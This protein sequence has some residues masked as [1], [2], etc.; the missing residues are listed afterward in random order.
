MRPSFRFDFSF[1]LSL[2]CCLTAFIFKLLKHMSDST[3]RLQFPLLLHLL[4]KIR[5]LMITTV[6]MIMA[7]VV[8]MMILLMM[9]SSSR[10]QRRG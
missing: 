8:E 3:P 2:N 6:M 1:S 10:Q 7:A 9:T 4:L 5:S